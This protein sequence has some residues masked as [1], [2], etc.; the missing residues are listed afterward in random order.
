MHRS[1]QCNILH[2]ASFIFLFHVLLL[3][4]LSMFFTSYHVDITDSHELWP[5]EKM[6]AAPVVQLPQ[7]YYQHLVQNIP[8]SRTYSV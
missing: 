1:H 5:F 2:Y 8:C 3:G 4:P 6:S 7:L